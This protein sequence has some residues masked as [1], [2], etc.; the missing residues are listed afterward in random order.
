MYEGGV[1][2]L[3]DSVHDL[4]E[5]LEFHDAVI[6]KAGYLFWN[7]VKGHYFVGGNKRTALLTTHMF[8]NYNGLFL[9]IR[10]GEGYLT[11]LRILHELIDE[12][13]LRVWIKDNS[14]RDIGKLEMAFTIRQID[15]K[16]LGKVSERSIAEIKE[17][18]EML[19]A[20]DEKIASGSILDGRKYVKH[21]MNADVNP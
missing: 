1:D 10:K 18:L 4:H 14:L 2:F 8:L 5:D 11:C 3:L 19:K 17:D 15:K 20:Y 13:E 16:R 9:R 12:K 6:A 21:L 7:L